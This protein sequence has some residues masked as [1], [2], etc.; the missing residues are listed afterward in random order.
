MTKHKL[1]L[2]NVKESESNRNFAIINAWANTVEDKLELQA[3]ETQDIHY[4]A[5]DTS[6]DPPE[7]VL[8]SKDGMDEAE[9][10]RMTFTI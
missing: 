4:L 2:P 7:L 10:G 3:L 1:S 5:L 8:L 6:V 9:V